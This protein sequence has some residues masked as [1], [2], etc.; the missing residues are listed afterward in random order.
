MNFDE[1]RQIAMSYP[2]VEEHI[3]FGGPTFKVG[4]RFLASIAKIDS[5]SLAL[6]LP[7]Q[8]QREFLVNSQPEI[9]YAPEHYANFGSVLIRLS[10]IEPEELRDLFEQAWRAYAPKR[11][12]AAYQ[13]PESKG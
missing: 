7:D 2:G 12:V 11:M 6:K 3:V 4:K 10:Q 1:V 13:T 9:F 5:D 8:L